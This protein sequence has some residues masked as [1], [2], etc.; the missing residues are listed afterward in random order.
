MAAQTPRPLRP[1]PIIESLGPYTP[2]ERDASIGL[3]LDSN[4]G[5]APIGS[6]RRVLACVDAEDLRRYRS[7]GALETRIAE[8]HGIDA[9]RVVVTNGAD[10]AIDRVC[11]AVLGEGRVMLTHTPSFEMITRWARIAGAGVDAVEWLDAPFP[12]EALVERIGDRVALVALVTPNNPTGAVVDTRTILEI[13]R[14]ASVRGVLVMVDLAYT[15]FADEDP[16]PDLV[17]EPNIV[18]VRTFSKALGIAGLRVGY[19]IAPDRVARWLRSSGGPFPCSSLSLAVAGACL[20]DP[21]IP[22]RIERTRAQRSALATLLGSLGVET[23]D[24][25][26]NFLCARFA[27]ADAVHGA[28]MDRGVS[29]RRFGPASVIRDRLR[30]TLP[31]D[32]TAFDRLTHALCDILGT[33][34]DR[35]ATP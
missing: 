5:V 27:D 35:G 13:A 11:R 1:R 26:A 18:L 7:P 12:T 30:I 16:T 20:G 17:R 3:I 15:E 4:E 25:G 34:S 32:E 2:P 14:T 28:L 21:S 31:G 33:P 6:A 29:V 10:D 22:E 9:G 23:I 24:S 19:A 8:H